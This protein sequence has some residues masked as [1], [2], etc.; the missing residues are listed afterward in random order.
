MPTIVKNGNEYLIARDFVHAV[1]M[2]APVSHG[3]FS[4]SGNSKVF[5]FRSD[6]DCAKSEK[7][8]RLAF[9]REG[10]R[11]TYIQTQAN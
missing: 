3:K 9:E 1:T 2:N 6:Y 11:I 10:K 7:A 8:L 4:Y 5:D